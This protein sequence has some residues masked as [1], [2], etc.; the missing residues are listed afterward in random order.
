MVAVTYSIRN[1][2]SCFH[3]SSTAVTISLT[4]AASLSPAS[5]LFSQAGLINNYLFILRLTIHNLW[6][7]YIPVRSTVRPL[8]IVNDSDGYQQYAASATEHVPRNEHARSG[9]VLRRIISCP[10]F[11]YKKAS[12]E[13]QLIRSS[14]R[15]LAAKFRFDHDMAL[16]RRNLSTSPPRQ[17]RTDDRFPLSVQQH[18]PYLCSNTARLNLQRS[19]HVK[20]SGL[21]FRP[22]A[23]NI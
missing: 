5:V 15:R 1:R 19:R 14:A 21:A 13:H 12:V 8:G 10:P 17:L 18:L 9:S 4:S 23:A 2:L 11:R 16:C 20:Y 3:L 22:I 7:T 6:N